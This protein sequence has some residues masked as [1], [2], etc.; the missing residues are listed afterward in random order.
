MGAKDAN[1]QL[2]DA[3][4]RIAFERPPVTDGLPALRGRFGQVHHELGPVAGPQ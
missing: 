4:A 1:A 2:A 3:L